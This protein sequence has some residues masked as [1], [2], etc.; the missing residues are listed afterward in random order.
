MHLGKLSPLVTEHLLLLYYV[1][2]QHVHLIHFQPPP[3]DWTFSPVF[4]PHY[5]CL[6]KT[7][8]N[9][10]QTNKKRISRNW[11]MNTSVFPTHAKAS[12]HE[13]NPVTVLACN[14]QEWMLCFT[15]EGK[16]H[17]KA[18]DKFWL[19]APDGLFCVGYS[20]AM[21]CTMRWDGNTPKHWHI[22]HTLMQQH[23]RTLTH[24]HT[25]YTKPH[26]HIQTTHIHT[27]HTHTHTHTLTQ[28]T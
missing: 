24:I 19:W 26:T 20:S 21:V 17:E 14:S 15:W 13:P 11:I 8:N 3:K 18:R 7:S 12:Q 1:C 5:C 27:D 23:V 16:G 4:P 28:H 9:N 6:V 22:G 2:S 25:P 10:K